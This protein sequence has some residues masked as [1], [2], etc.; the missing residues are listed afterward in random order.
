MR[1]RRVRADR[2]RIYEKA[3]DDYAT[4]FADGVPGEA[5]V[6]DVLRARILCYHTTSVLLMID[7]LK[8]PEG[9]QITPSGMHAAEYGEMHAGAVETVTL[10]MVRLK[11]KCN[12]S[13]RATLAPSATP[14]SRL[15]V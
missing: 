9:F 11:N 8:R 2:V 3:G 15:R 13:A 1:E 12:G 4:R 14:P 10:K 5:N 7:E 6:V